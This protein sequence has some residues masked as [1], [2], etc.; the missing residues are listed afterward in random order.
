MT[1]DKDNRPQKREQN[2]TQKI[3]MW[4]IYGVAAVLL[5]VAIVIFISSGA[6]LF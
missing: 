1:L 6:S 2:R 3:V 4:S 5:V